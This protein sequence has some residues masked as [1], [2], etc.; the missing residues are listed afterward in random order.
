MA[1][2]ILH[3]ENLPV[4]FYRQSYMGSLNGFHLVPALFVFGPSV[5]LV[6]LNAVAW[7]LLFPLGLYVLAR[8]I[9]DESAARVTLLLA[10][11]P[12]F[13]LTYYSTVAEPH[14]ETN[15]FGVI[16]LLLAL[17]ALMAP[18]EPHRARALACLGFIA[19]LACWTNAKTAVVLGPILLL[20]LVHDPRLPL[21]RGGLLFAAGFLVGNLPAWLFYATHPDP[22][23]DGFGSAKRFLQVDLNVSWEKSADFL[24]RVLQYPVGSYY[25]GPFTPGRTAG[26]V[27][28]CALHVAA[29]AL[30]GSEAVRALRGGKPTR[31][32]WG[33]WLLLLTLVVT[34]A[35]LYGS[36]FNVLDD[37]S[38]GRYLLPA[39]IPLLLFL[40]AAI[41]R[42]ARRSR[43]AAGAVLAFVLAFHLWTNLEF[44]WPLQPDKQARRATEIATREALAQR[45]RAGTADAILVDTGRSSFLWQFL[46]DKAIVS[47]FMT[48]GYYPSAVAADAAAR[49][50][51]LV[52]QGDGEMPAQLRALGATATAT[53]F[54]RQWLYQ[55][56]RIPNRSYRLVP[57]AGWRSLG[58]SALPPAVADGN[59]GTVWPARRLDRSD[60]G[61]LVLDLGAL[62][63]VARLV[64]WPT[65]LTD[66]IVPLEVAGSLDA[67]TW[68]R[69]GVTPARVAQPVFAVGQR[70]LFRPRNGWLELV[71]AP[72]LVRYLRV[73]PVESGSIGV[74]MVGELFAY[75]A[76]DQPPAEA[77]D[78][79]ALAPCP[80]CPRRDA[81]PG[82][83]GRVRSDRLGD[84]G[85]RG[86][87]A[88]QPGPQQ[89]RTCAPD[90]ALRQPS[91]SGDGRGP[92]AGRGRWGATRAAR[93]GGRARYVGADRAL[94]PVPAGRAAR[95]VGPLPADRLARD[96]RGARGGR[97]RR[98]LRRRGAPSRGDARGHDPL[99]APAGLDPARG[100]S[101]RRAVRR[102]PHLAGGGGRAAR[103]GMGMGRADAL[104]ALG[105]GVRAGGGRC[106]GERG[107]GG[108]PA[109]V[110]RPG[111]DY[112]SL[113]A[114]L[115]IAGKGAIVVR[116]GD[117]RRVVSFAVARPTGPRWRSPRRIPMGRRSDSSVGSC[118]PRA[119]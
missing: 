78:V 68:Q 26:L 76:L 67:V 101:R 109:A 81:A 94:R 39:Y 47:E 105:R 44:L 55:D 27:L 14:F 70:P 106:V 51:I 90:A 84:E 36:R 33:V 115:G 7:S 99:R 3:S 53:Q 9:Y 66:V 41:A 58:E 112:L 32:A 4:F 100:D 28:C 25:F 16:L 87:R 102:R 45:L 79:D 59:L 73:R 13:L 43:L 75:E 37:D 77:L 24:T 88:C 113:R 21:R 62:R 72:Q 119:R 22:G 104:H 108:G 42:L 20:L 17:G 8:R 30:A 107:A 118:T 54:G 49:V 97:P 29:V 114:A 103:A 46:L 50:A 15:T 71:T 95:H 52:T 83:P 34:Y 63:P 18:A 2:H 64:L 80:P 85:D 6:R 1:K 19:G 86:H 98:A 12:P 82:R 65:A 56:I 48:D 89:P 60:A 111:S 23:P 11:V 110:P 92:G 35:A 69:L 93:G 74:G 116:G 40:G 38:R 117:R 57:R 5:L 61:E 96:G 31:R 10:A 91:V